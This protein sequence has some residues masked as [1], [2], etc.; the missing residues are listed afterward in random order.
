MRVVKKSRGRLCSGSSEVGEEGRKMG[1]DGGSRI[2]DGL[3]DSRM[4]EKGT[5]KRV[6]IRET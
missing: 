3:R 6:Q 2:T 5:E 1:P 4:G